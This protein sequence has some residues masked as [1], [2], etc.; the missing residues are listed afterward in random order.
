MDE[1]TNHLDMMSKDILKRALKDYD[2][3]LIVVSHD[4][5]FLQGLTEKVYE[6]KNKNIKEY[7]GDINA[8]LAD[9]DLMDFKQLEQTDKKESKKDKVKEQLSYHQNKKQTREKRKLQNRISK[10]EKQID[11]LEKEMKQLDKQLADAKQFQE[12]S[13]QKGF[14]EKYEQNQQKLK[15]MV[16]DWEIAVE[17]LEC[18]RI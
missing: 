9:R 13:K 6:F 4:R 17:Q 3:S 8:F 1:P 16:K 18:Q 14:F 2:G 12:L 5:D 11:A 10:L 15:E 7:I